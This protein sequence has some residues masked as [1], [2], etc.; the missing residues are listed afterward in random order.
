MVIQA[1][2]IYGALKSDCRRRKSGSLGK[3]IK[4]CVVYLSPQGRVS[5]ARRARKAFQSSLG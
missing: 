1:E 4:P 5:D 2:P 3:K